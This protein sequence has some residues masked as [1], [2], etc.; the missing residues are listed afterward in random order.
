R[1]ARG[2]LQLALDVLAAEPMPAD[3]LLRGVTDAIISPHIGGP[4]VDQLPGLG[5]GAAENI[6]RYLAG[7][8][9][10]HAMTPEFYDR[11]T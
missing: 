2:D 1:A 4:T 9:L 7:E 5:R 8:P 10:L 3:S 6:R 11:S